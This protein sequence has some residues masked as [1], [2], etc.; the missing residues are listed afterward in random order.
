MRR[1]KLLAHG[2]CALAMTFDVHDAGDGWSGQ[3][4]GTLAERLRSSTSIV[5]FQENV[6]FDHYF[7]SYPNAANPPASSSAQRERQPSTD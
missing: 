1:T 5:L 7:A 6:S 4:G 2:I 3:V